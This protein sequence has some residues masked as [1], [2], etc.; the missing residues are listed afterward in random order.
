[1][2]PASTWA[3]LLGFTHPPTHLDVQSSTG[4]KK[5]KKKKKEKKREKNSLW[6]IGDRTFTFR[7]PMAKKKKKKKKRKRERRYSKM[8]D[9]S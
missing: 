4:H 1:M 6:G 2:T 7:A 5:K 9:R 3:S 8:G